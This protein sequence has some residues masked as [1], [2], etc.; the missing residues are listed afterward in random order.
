MNKTNDRCSIKAFSTTVIN[1]SNPALGNRIIG[2]NVKNSS[3]QL[4]A[5]KQT[6]EVSNSSYFRFW[7]LSHNAV[8]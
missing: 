6:V 1:F 3:K 2:D 8:L 4:V 7:C 5:L